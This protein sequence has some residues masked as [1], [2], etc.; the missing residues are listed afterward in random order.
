[1]CIILIKF[2]QFSLCIFLI[3][4]SAFSMDRGLEPASHRGVLRVQIYLWSYTRNKLDHG[5]QRHHSQG[6]E[7]LA[8]FPSICTL[9]ISIYFMCLHIK[10]IFHILAQPLQKTLNKKGTCSLA[11]HIART[12]ILL[13][14]GKKH[15]LRE[16]YN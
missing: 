7:L 15:W 8:K 13:H 12:K 1:M 6:H 10:Y 11:C 4:N 5:P 2:F 14:L 3:C 16:E 9:V